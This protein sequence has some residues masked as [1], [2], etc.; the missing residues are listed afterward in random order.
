M[1]YEAISMLPL[2]DEYIASFTHDRVPA[3]L[4]EA[5]DAIR[6]AKT[7]D[8]VSIHLLNP[9]KIVKDAATDKL[10]ILNNQP[11]VARNI[12]HFARWGQI[13]DGRI[14]PQLMAAPGHFASRSE[15]FNVVEHGLG[16]VPGNLAGSVSESYTAFTHHLQSRVLTEETVKQADPYAMQKPKMPYGS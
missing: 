3:G 6:R 8:E 13:Y 4:A 15:S 16:R 12:T 5:R 11:P 7:A 10:R 9:H 2:L 14:A 1:Y